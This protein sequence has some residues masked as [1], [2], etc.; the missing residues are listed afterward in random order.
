VALNLLASTAGVWLASR[1]PAR[2]LALGVA[3]LFAGFGVWTLLAA[4][5]KPAD[6][7]P[8]SSRGAFLT[9]AGLFFV[10]EL[11]DKTQ[12]AAVALAAQYGSIVAVTLGATLGMLVADGLA[13]FLGERL[14]DKIP[15]RALRRGT[16]ALF[17]LFAAVALYRWIT[18][19]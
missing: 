9:T 15:V 18:S 12:I 8:P 3:V 7:K 5:E 14:A 17:F 2:S 19:R 16:A 13:V 6:E 1:V 4:D 11:G 10:A